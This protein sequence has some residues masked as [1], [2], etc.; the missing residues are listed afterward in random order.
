MDIQ[1]LDRSY[2]EW[3]LARIGAQ[4]AERS[5]YS[6]LKAFSDAFRD[7]DMELAASMLRF[8]DAEGANVESARKT[9]EQAQ[10]RLS[11]AS[12]PD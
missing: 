9:Y 2:R 7:G 10:T 6:A 1:E 5:H 3:E 11:A 4:H 8:A 12:H